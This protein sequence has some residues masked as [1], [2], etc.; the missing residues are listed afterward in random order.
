M[1]SYIGA[2]QTTAKNILKHLDASGTDYRVAVAD[3]KDFPIGPYGNTGD[4]PY[5]ADL[6]FSTDKAAIYNA[7]DNLSSIVGGG[8]D[9]PESAYSGLIRSIDTEGL[10]SWRNGAKKAVIV[11]SDAAPL[12]P[13]PFTNYQLK[14]VVDAANAVDPAAIYSIVPGGDPSAVSYFSQLSTE[15]GGKLY[16]TSSS[17]DI[18]NALIDIT[19]QVTTPPSVPEPD[20]SIGTYIGLSILG[21]GCFLK[22]KLSYS[23]DQDKQLGVKS[24]TPRV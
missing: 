13:E 17:D 7:I 1:G 10:G 8:G 5:H 14:D 3:Y 22:K 6:S 19:D 12:D 11:M 18:A 16:T 20:P 24:L 4:Y 2:V 9:I 23:I 21:I 15:T